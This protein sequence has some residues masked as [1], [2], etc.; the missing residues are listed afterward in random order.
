MR[1][2]KMARGMRIVMTA[3]GLKPSSR[4]GGR[5][6]NLLAHGGFPDP[7]Y[8]EKPLDDV[9]QLPVIPG[10]SDQP[11]ESPAETANDHA[12]PGI[13]GQQDAGGLGS[14]AFY[15]LQEIG[16]FHFRHPVVGNDEADLFRADPFE[17]LPGT[18]RRPDREGLAPEGAFQ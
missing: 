10:F 1:E 17:R 15:F 18:G 6:T 9:D 8:L 13:A 5:R 12:L 7:P 2:P 14:R 16:P 4:G 3:D 11:A